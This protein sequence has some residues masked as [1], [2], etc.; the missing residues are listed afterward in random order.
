MKVAEPDSWAAE[1]DRLRTAPLAVLVARY[2]DLFGERPRTR[3]RV[4]L[5]RRIAWRLQANLQ[6]GLTERARA[7]ALEIAGD[8]DLRLTAPRAA[9]GT[10]ARGRNRVCTGSCSRRPG[11]AAGA[12]RSTGVWQGVPVRSLRADGNRDGAGCWPQ[13]RSFSRGQWN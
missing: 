5:L 12:G 10:G 2:E 4:W 9:K 6:G 7:R 1:A 3:H 13:R 8:R 11:V